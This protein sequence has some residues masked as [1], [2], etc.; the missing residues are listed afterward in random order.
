MTYEAAL[1]RVCVMARN[2]L[3]CGL[4][5]TQRGD[6]RALEKIVQFLERWEN[7]KR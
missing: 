6:R 4:R 3:E 2:D 1:K 5:L 7:E